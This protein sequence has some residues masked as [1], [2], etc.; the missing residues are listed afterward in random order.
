MEAASQR[1]CRVRGRSQGILLWI[2]PPT[3]TKNSTHQRPPQTNFPPDDYLCVCAPP[4]LPR[5]VTVSTQLLP[6]A[7]HALKKERN[8]SL[9]G[10]Y[11]VTIIPLTL[12]LSLLFYFNFK[13]LLYNTEVKSWI[14]LKKINLGY[15]LLVFCPIVYLNNS[16]LT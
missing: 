2:S 7:S 16:K 9:L 13:Y 8:A 5:I 3:C 10:S 4:S 6:S 15:R 14:Q 12:I 1:L 11:E